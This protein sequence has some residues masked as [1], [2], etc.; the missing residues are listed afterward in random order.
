[1]GG[2]HVPAG[3]VPVPEDLEVALKALVAAHGKRKTFEALRCSQFTLE[4]AIVEGAR[5][6]PKTID[7]LRARLPEAL[8]KFAETP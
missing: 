8:A 2:S 4:D 5:M 3:R 1:M 7:A 6:R